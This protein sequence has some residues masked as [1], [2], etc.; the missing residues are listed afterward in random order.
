MLLYGGLAI[1]FITEIVLQIILV[2]LSVRVLRKVNSQKK[3]LFGTLIIGALLSALCAWLFFSLPNPK[4]TYVGIVMAI[5]TIG[6][7]L[8]AGKI[9]GIVKYAGY[10]IC[11]MTIV[12]Y[13]AFVIIVAITAATQSL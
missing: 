2:V 6:Y 5:S 4:T 11:W 8:S 9:N 3:L 12:T 13:F 7:I 1:I 10:S